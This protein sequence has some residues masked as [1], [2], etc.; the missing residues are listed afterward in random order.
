[1]LSAM[2]FVD[3]EECYDIRKC[4][5]RKF[6]KCTI[7]TGTYLKSGQCPFCKEER[8]V[9]DGVNYKPNTIKNGRPRYE[10]KGA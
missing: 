2:H 6:F 1:M 8:D 9:T 4:F 5:A 7:L 10:K 3:G